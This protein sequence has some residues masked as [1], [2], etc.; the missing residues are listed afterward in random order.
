MSVLEMQSI[1]YDDMM[2]L[3]YSPECRR[4]SYLSLSSSFL[5]DSGK[6]TD[7]PTIGRR[8]VAPVKDGIFLDASLHFAWPMEG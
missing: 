2:I 8:F 3:K 6:P 5:L 4:C 1:A 7:G